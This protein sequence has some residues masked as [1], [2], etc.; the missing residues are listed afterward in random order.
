MLNR[1]G[2][3]TRKRGLS[4]PKIKDTH[5]EL[6]TDD[7]GG[8]IEKEFEDRRRD[9]RVLVGGGENARGGG[10]LTTVTD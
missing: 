7:K 4:R 5:D 6:G 9:A 2:L 3:S 8:N 1:R 10:G